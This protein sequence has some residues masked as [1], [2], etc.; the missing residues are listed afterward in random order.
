MFSRV[1]RRR[2]VFIAYVRT[3]DA[4]ED[5]QPESQPKR[6]PR[7][8][9]RKAPSNSS[10]NLPIFYVTALILISVGVEKNGIDIAYRTAEGS[11]F[12]NPVY[13]ASLEGLVIDADADLLHGSNE[14]A[15]DDF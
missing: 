10:M 6:P 2:D 14:A 9:Q 13:D 1:D 11:R 4:D 12:G 7:K 15:L 5:T 3:D 8:R